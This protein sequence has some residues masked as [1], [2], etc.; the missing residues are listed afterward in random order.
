MVHITS[1]LPPFNLYHVQWCGIGSL[2]STP[3][4]LRTTQREF[5]LRNSAGSA[6]EEKSSSGKSL[7]RKWAS[8]ISIWLSTL[9]EGWCRLNVSEDGNV[10]LDIPAKAKI[11]G[12]M[13]FCSAA[14]F[15][16][17]TSLLPPSTYTNHET[18]ILEGYDSKNMDN[19][20][21]HVTVEMKLMVR[22][23]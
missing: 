20:M 13:Q 19:S 2:F 9:E 21:L 1:F 23:A 8:L 22:F 14:S 12:Y 15:S 10:D 3:S 17:S 4:W 11:D 18:G 5:W 7:P 16:L 6:L